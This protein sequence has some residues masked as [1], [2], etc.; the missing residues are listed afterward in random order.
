MRR[1][2]RPTTQV[3]SLESAEERSETRIFIVTGV[4]AAG[5]TVAEKKKAET[6]LF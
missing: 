6:T 1:T 4:E 2:V 3:L 5:L